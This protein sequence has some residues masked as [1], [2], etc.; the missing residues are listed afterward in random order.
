MPS[1]GFSLATAASAG[2]RAARAF[3]DPA[4]D[5]F[6]SVASLWEIAIK[7]SLDRLVLTPDWFRTIES[8][9]DANAIGWV[10]I[11]SGHCAHVAQLP[12]HHRDPFDRMLVVQARA[13]GMTLVSRDRSFSAYDVRT[14]W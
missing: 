8:E 10:P 9:L 7:C 13:E 12:F 6:V 4:N 3:E 1:S 2:A 5:A 11:R 14:L